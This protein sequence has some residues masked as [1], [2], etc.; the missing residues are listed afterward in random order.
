MTGL[1]PIYDAELSWTIWITSSSWHCYSNITVCNGTQVVFQHST[2]AHNLTISR[3][4]TVAFT[5]AWE[6]ANQTLLAAAA[7]GGAYLLR[8]PLL[9]LLLLLLGVKGSIRWRE[10]E[11]E[12]ERERDR[13]NFLATCFPFARAHARCVYYICAYPKPNTHERHHSIN[14]ERRS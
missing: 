5:A 12:R 3:E 1:C 7:T 13:E 11:R 14:L 8:F 4:A 10:R 9:L 2:A 6:L